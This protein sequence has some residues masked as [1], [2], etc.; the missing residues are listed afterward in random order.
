MST[1]RRLRLLFKIAH[2][3]MRIICEFTIDECIEER[4]KRRRCRHKMKIVTDEKPR[5]MIGRDVGRKRRRRRG[6]AGE[7]SSEITRNNG[8]R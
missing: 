1:D 3:I 8:E 6:R 7:I 4:K 5:E 2:T